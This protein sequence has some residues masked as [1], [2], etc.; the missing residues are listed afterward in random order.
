MATLYDCRIDNA[1]GS[2]TDI[3]SVSALGWGICVQYING[4]VIFGGESMVSPAEVENYLSSVL[5]FDDP[6][7]TSAALE[8]ADG[9]NFTDSSSF[10]YSC[11]KLTLEYADGTTQQTSSTAHHSIQLT[12]KTSPLVDIYTTV[13]SFKYIVNF[14]SII[15]DEV[16]PTALTHEFIFNLPADTLFRSW[17]QL[18]DLFVIGLGIEPLNDDVQP[19]S[20]YCEV[21]GGSDTT[22][23]TINV[24]DTFDSVDVTTKT[25][26]VLAV[27]TEI[28]ETYYQAQKDEAA[29]VLDIEATN[30]ILTDLYEQLQTAE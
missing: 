13:P 3:T 4:G 17:K 23:T 11:R 7:I 25:R 6:S 26:S 1:F 10:P 28:L 27:E 24:D 5:G 22:T 18:K 15:G 12:S 2:T 30:T 21:Q 9:S 14:T 29:G 16:L 19:I 8:G 20:I